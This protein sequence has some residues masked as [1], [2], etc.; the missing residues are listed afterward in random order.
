LSGKQILLVEDNEMNRLIATTV[1][2]RYGARVCEAVNGAEA[3]SRLKEGCY[4][5]ILMDMQM[6]VMDG[7][8]ATRL[9][10]RDIDKEVPII[11]LTA[12]AIKGEDEHCI[13]AGMNAYVPKPFDER[14]LIHTLVAWI[15]RRPQ[16]SHL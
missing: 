13:A 14:Q 15:G 5:A 9:I 16:P 12:N 3:I 7:L 1:L 6:P 2:G 10:R 11:A 4:D 8:E